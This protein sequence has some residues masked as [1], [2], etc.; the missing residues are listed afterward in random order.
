MHGSFCS[1]LD[2]SHRWSCATR[3]LITQLTNPVAQYSHFDG[4]AVIGGFVYRGTLAPILS[5]KYVCGDL[6]GPAG[7]GRLFFSN[8]T[9]G[10][11]EEFDLAGQRDPLLG[12]FLKGF[13]QDDAGEIYVLIHS[14]IG[15]SGTGG[16][17]LKIIEAE[18]TP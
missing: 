6:A 11:V 13:D 17:V 7:S 16:H 10:M 4:L 5:G 12:S 2:C 3:R 8:L 14:N 15:P 9:S 18:S 1:Y